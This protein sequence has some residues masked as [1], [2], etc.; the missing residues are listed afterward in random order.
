MRYEK[1]MMARWDEYVYRKTLREE[2]IEKGIEKGMKKG[3]KKGAREK[4]CEFIKALLAKG[5]YTIRDIADLTGVSEAFV[6]KV[7][8]AV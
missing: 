5:G 1:N 3:M 7:K 8:K 6:R 2:G 4:T